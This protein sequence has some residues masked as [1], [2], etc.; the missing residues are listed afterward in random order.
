MRI[1]VYLGQALQ[2]T[3]GVYL[4]AVASYAANLP[5]V[6]LVR[7]LGFRPRLDPKAL[8]AEIR[9]WNLDRIAIAGD[10]PGYFKPAFARAMRMAGRDPSQVF[11]ASFREHGAETSDATQR[12]KAIVACA[13]WGVPFRLVAVPIQTPVYP[14]IIAGM[15]GSIS[16]LTDSTWTMTWT[17]L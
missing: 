2:P 3:T 16:G 13:V 6:E 15:S 5:E 8:A 1:G 9:E 11:T 14:P 10:S 4:D 12:A 17:S 7:Q